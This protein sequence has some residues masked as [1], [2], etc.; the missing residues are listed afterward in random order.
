MSPSTS[1]T[2][3]LTLSG[4]QPLWTV[5]RVASFFGVSESWL[6]RLVEANLIP[7][8]RLGGNIRFH[9]VELVDWFNTQRAGPGGGAR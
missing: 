7:H 6:Y 2:L 3:P 5:R 4:P 1:T 8:V 9:Y